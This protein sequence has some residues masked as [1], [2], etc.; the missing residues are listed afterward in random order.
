MPFGLCNATT[1]FQRVMAQALIRVT[2]KYGNLGMCYVDDVVI[3]TPTPEDHIDWLDEVFGC[4]K[5]AGLKCKPSKCEILRDSNSIKYLGRMVDRHGVRPDPEAV[6][7]VL[8]WKAPRTD[9]QLM[10][11]LGFANYYR[12]FIKGYAD[13]LYPI[14]KL[15]RNKGKKFEWNEEA[16]AAFEKHKAG[17]VQSA[18]ARYAYREGHVCS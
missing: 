7:A 11:F 8:T 10:S 2:K 4:M 14:Q 1:T 15:M 18:S 12:E 17:T 16:Q 3:A 5:R 6:E 13:K 9:A